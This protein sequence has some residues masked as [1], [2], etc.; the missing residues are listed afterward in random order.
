[1]EKVTANTITARTRTATIHCDCFMTPPGRSWSAVPACFMATPRPLRAL[2]LG[3]LLHAYPA[4]GPPSIA[5]LHRLPGLGPRFA[6][7]LGATARFLYADYLDRASDDNF[8]DALVRF[9]E[10]SVPAP[11][12]AD[13]LRRRAGFVR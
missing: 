7:V 3:P 8:R 13:T 6:A 1:M 5:E 9:Y 11:L 10:S 4:A 12:H 2:P